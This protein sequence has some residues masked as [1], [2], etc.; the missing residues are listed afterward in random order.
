MDAIPDDVTL[1]CTQYTSLPIPA[2]IMCNDDCHGSWKATLTDTK[3]RFTCEDSWLIFRRW[4]C[5]DS[6]GHE[7]HNIQTITLVDQTP[8]EFAVGYHPNIDVECEQEPPVLP[9]TAT[10]DC[11]KYIQVHSENLGFSL[12]Y[13]ISHYEQ[14]W[15]AVDNCGNRVSKKR[16]VHIVDT[17]DP[18]IDHK[19]GDVTI[20]CHN[21]G[22]YVLPE[23][24]CSDNCGGAV[25][26]RNVETI[27]GTCEQEYKVAATWLCTDLHN[28]TDSHSMT[29]TVVDNEPPVIN[30][31]DL[32]VT[33]PCD[34][35]PFEPRASVSDNCDTVTLQYSE[36]KVYPDYVVGSVATPIEFWSNVDT[37]PSGFYHPTVYYRLPADA[38][39][40]YSS[41]R[42]WDL[43][44]CEFMCSTYPQC[45]G[46]QYT[47]ELCLFYTLSEICFV[48]NEAYKIPGSDTA[49][50][51]RS[52]YDGSQSHYAIASDG[53]CDVP[54][55]VIH[56][57]DNYEMSRH[58]EATDDCGNKVEY[59]H[60]ITVFDN[61]APTLYNVPEDVTYDCTMTTYNAIP[62]PSDNRVKWVGSFI[63]ATHG[64]KAPYAL[65]VCSP[66]VKVKEDLTYAW[67]ECSSNLVVVFTWVATDDCGLE[68]VGT[69]T[70]TK[71]DNTP[72]ILGYIPEDADV[73]CVDPMPEPV[74]ITAT[75]DCNEVTV[76]VSTQY[77]NPGCN[78]QMIHT[79][80]ATD[81][82]GNSASGQQILHVADTKPPVFTN[83]PESTTVDCASGIYTLTGPEVDDECGEAQVTESSSTE[84]LDCTSNIQIILTW[85]G[86]DECGNK[87]SVVATIT[88][89]DTTFPSIL[90]VP[91]DETVECDTVWKNPGI[92]AVDDCGEAVLKFQELI[93]DND[94]A[95][96]QIF[97]TVY[98]QWTATDLC[99]HTTVN[100]QTVVVVDEENP[101]ISVPDDSNIGCKDDVPVYKASFDDDCGTDEGFL[102]S[103]T[104]TVA[105]TCESNY[106]IITTYKAQDRCGNIHSKDHTIHV[107]DTEAPVLVGVPSNITVPCDQIPDVANV[108][109]KDDCAYPVPHFDETSTRD[110][111]CGS[112][113]D[114]IRCWWVSDNCGNRV[115][116]CQTIEVYDNEGPVLSCAGADKCEDIGIECEIYPPIPPV[117]VHDNCYE[118][119]EIDYEVSYSH[120][121]CKHDHQE[122]RTWTTD[123]CSGNTATL[124][125]TVTYYDHTPPILEGF[126]PDLTVECPNEVPVPPVVANDNCDYLLDVDYSSTR[127]KLYDNCDGT[128]VE[129]RKWLASDFCGNSDYLTQTISVTDKTPP[130]LNIYAND[131]EVECDK[132]ASI[133]PGDVTAQD[134]CDYDVSV[135]FL[136]Q[137]FDGT[138]EDSFKLIR[139]WRAED[140]HGNSVNHAQTLFVVD[141]IPPYFIHAPP[142][143]TTISQED[144]YATEV[145]LEDPFSVTAHDNCADP[146]VKFE[147]V[148]IPWTMTVITPIIVSVL[149]VFMMIVET[150]IKCNKLLN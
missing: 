47:G 32:K 116:R 54:H 16:T 20:S 140:C 60:L 29:I 8:P 108:Q 122:F 19:A 42:G 33:V 49:K 43:T 103:K 4:S 2:D 89:L 86:Q 73:E 137:K 150:L 120:G 35:V 67:G 113:Y 56:F 99:G 136:E 57:C 111:Y 97:Y 119:L 131:A 109:V 31:K 5:K 105:G 95:S 50:T 144:F 91:D 34:E 25:L 74:T 6:C 30:V 24:H 93:E 72:P 94:C 85:T 114:L 63:S 102:D 52:P 77:K 147:E 130:V 123:D 22:A 128:Y 40:H 84:I 96:T 59:K 62:A 66:K 10:D 51:I 149:G 81:E 14:M 71:W 141:S 26:T 126:C 9:A 90:N 82:C 45:K 38:A 129:Y 92:T 146:S 69:M 70:L 68:A 107:F 58:W 134:D 143:D 87:D 76:V 37:S 23:P 13:T 135:K 48:Q 65:D 112:P 75:D 21:Y 41:R 127:E 17:H 124:T 79:W 36:D 133:W 55:P 80:V 88:K 121:T 39:P 1:N 142:Q 15:F 110:G 115:A 44:S 117:T 139:S 83:E 125:Q 46:V 104:V 12:G 28:R 100:S 11:A 98:R 145:T 3:E 118:H 61:A 138:C 106:D 101:T 64:I 132:I 27:P 148:T 7:I 78:Y 53:L 18:V